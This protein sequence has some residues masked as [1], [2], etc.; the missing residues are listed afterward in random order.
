MSVEQE[1]RSFAPKGLA[2]MKRDPL[3]EH[4][5]NG[6][7]GRAIREVEECVHE[8][9]AALGR[10][11]ASHRKHVNKRLA[12]IEQQLAG[13]RLVVGVDDKGNVI[14]KTPLLMSRLAFFSTFSGAV[15]GLFLVVQLG[16]ALWPSIHSAAGVVWNFVLHYGAP[17]P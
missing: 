2:R 8:T 16:N 3:P 14:R 9:G 4:P 1:P 12:T 10:K 6:A 13:V 7:L 15:V 11:L 17:P 5:D